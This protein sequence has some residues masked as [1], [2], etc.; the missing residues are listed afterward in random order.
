MLG[1]ESSR[2]SSSLERVD[3]YK[4]DS[5]EISS[6]VCRPLS[7]PLLVWFSDESQGFLVILCCLVVNPFFAV[8]CHLFLLISSYLA[9]CY[10]LKINSKFESKLFSCSWVFSLHNFGWSNPSCKQGSLVEF[11]ERLLF[12][13]PLKSPFRSF[14]KTFKW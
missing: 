14:N 13:L 5:S 12:T 1:F 4:Q 7:L 6:H 2:S 10:N 8:I 3:E 9:S 11:L